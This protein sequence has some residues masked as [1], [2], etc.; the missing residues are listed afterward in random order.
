MLKFIDGYGTQSI[1]CS[2]VEMPV[3]PVCADAWQ[4]HVITFASGN[5]AELRNPPAECINL[6]YI[7]PT[8][9]TQTGGDGGPATRPPA[10]ALDRADLIGPYFECVGFVDAAGLAT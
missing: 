1:D 2:H 4:P 9:D 6:L 8:V 3:Q 10:S 7:D 5:L